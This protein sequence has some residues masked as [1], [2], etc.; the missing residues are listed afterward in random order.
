M[1]RISRCASCGKRIVSEVVE[2][3]ERR[4]RDETQT[5]F[6]ALAQRLDRLLEE[7]LSA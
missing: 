4:P 3:S 2:G 1:M 6:D 7:R 5:A